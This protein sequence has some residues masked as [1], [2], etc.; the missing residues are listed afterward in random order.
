M[1]FFTFF[2]IFHNTITYS[3]KLDRTAS[4]H[5]IPI[6][7]TPWAKYC[8]RPAATNQRY[9]RLQAT[10]GDS[11][12]EMFSLA[13]FVR[14]L[15]SFKFTTSNL[16]LRYSHTYFLSTKTLTRL[17]ANQDKKHDNACKH[18][19]KVDK[20]SFVYILLEVR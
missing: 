14:N 5:V 12:H 7:K 3:I 17:S 6:I 1:S 11:Y 9:I 4:F 20:Q 13:V 2:Y 16:Q 18:L 15:I 10:L 19:Y 8:L